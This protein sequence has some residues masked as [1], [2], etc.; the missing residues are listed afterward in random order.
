MKVVQIDFRRYEWENQLQKMWNVNW[1]QKFFDSGTLLKLNRIP[2]SDGAL[3]V[4]ILS[5]RT[6][7]Q[8]LREWRLE[9]ESNWLWRH[10]S[11]LI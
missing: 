2:G 9:L 8:T 5:A 10:V 6:V 4:I 11:Q 3:R 7:G 1:K